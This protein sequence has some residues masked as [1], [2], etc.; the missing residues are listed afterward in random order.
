MKPAPACHCESVNARLADFLCENQERISQ[1]WL[2]RVKADP[3]V[4]TESLTMAQLKDHVP[5]LINNLAETL[6]RYGSKSVA[7]KSADDAESHGE[8]RWEQ[9]YEPSDLLREIKH[10][11]TILIFH[12][13]S[14]QE[15]NPDFGAASRLFADSTLH[16]F[17]D[18]MA[19]GA[20]EEF[21]KSQTEH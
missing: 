13:L 17:L 3:A 4:P 19:I 16:Q 7:D 18:D 8:I 15:L 9:G 11:R 6:R 1:E 10:L 20:T 5:R 14:F 12:L 21:L 2:D